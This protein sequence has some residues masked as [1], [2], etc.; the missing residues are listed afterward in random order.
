MGKES[1]IL[2]TR[3]WKPISRLSD[4]QLG[5]LF[6]ALYMY[7]T[8]EQCEV[9]DDILMAYDFFVNQFELD[10]QKY[11][12][13]IE[14]R[15]EGGKKGA[16]NRRSTEQSEECDSPKVNQGELRSPKV[17]QGHPRSPKVTQGNLRSVK[18]TQGDPS[19][20]D[21]DNVN[22][23]DNV[24]FKEKEIKKEKEIFE[25]DSSIRAVAAEMF[26][27]KFRNPIAEAQRFCEYNAGKSLQSSYAYIPAW[28][29]I[30][31]RVM[32]DEPLHWLTH[33]IYH[34]RD[35]GNPEPLYDII[36]GISEITAIGGEW[37]MHCTKQAMQAIEA[38]ATEKPKCRLKYNIIKLSS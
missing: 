16:N 25:S 18:V 33:V 17:T 19:L 22:V 37:I 2:Y 36:T 21:N 28:K 10:D 34:A 7:Q 26:L 9:D 5:R 11:N 30:S 35:E 8:G 32:P 14:A 1:F 20:N 24:F 12:D 27:R 23:N 29:P 3:F 38:N 6:R 13:I 4:E 15:R 31:T